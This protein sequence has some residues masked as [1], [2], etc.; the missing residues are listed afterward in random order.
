[1]KTLTQIEATQA[2]MRGNIANNKTLL[3]GVQESFASSLN[4][5]NSTVINLDARIKALK[6]K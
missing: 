5:I 3:Q 6:K 2:E 1:M 4:E